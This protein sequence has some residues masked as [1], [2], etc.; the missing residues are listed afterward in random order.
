MGGYP[1]SMI[2]DKSG[3]KGLVTNVV[4]RVSFTHCLIHRFAL[5]MKTLLF[6]LQKVLQ[7]V[8]KI[9]NHISANATKSRLFPAFCEEVGSDYKVLLLHME[10][11]WLSRG[12]SLNRLLQ[13]R[14]EAA[15]FLEKERNA[16]GVDMHNQLKS[17]DFLLKVAYL[18][19]F[20]SEVNSLK[21]TLQGGCQ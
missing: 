1:P 10:V 18:G 20:F 9:V 17:N 6:G 21:Y 15:I 16:K 3:F 5:A 14:E 11:R 12:K 13:L 8:V 4:P 19:D 7:D 2:G